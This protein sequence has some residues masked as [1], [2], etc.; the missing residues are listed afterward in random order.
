MVENIEF[1]AIFDGNN[2]KNT[3]MRIN[4][5]QKI[6]GSILML[7]PG[8]A[9][10]IGDK[11]SRGY[12][13]CKLDKT[14]KEIKFIFSDFFKYSG[15]VKLVNL[16]DVRQSNSNKFLKIPEFKSLEEIKKELKDSP[17][18]WIAWTCKDNG[19]LRKLRA[20]L[21]EFL[22]KNDKY[23]FGKKGKINNGYYH[24]GVRLKSQRTALEKEIN[25]QL[26]IIFR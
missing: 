10:Y 13:L 23:T 24:P 9:R 25:G 22:L 1:W 6:L 16:S 4:G 19:E 8:S 26:K 14:M 11:D 7:N 21:L 17:W 3:E 2:R 15:T 5:D 18:V 20:R 12:Q